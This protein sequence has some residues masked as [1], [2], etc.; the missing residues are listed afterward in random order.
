MNAIP[1]MCPTEKILG[2]L[3]WKIKKRVIFLS[4]NHLYF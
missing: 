3:A 2:F 4:E 1:D